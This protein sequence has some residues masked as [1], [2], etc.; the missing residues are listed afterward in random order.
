MARESPYRWGWLRTATTR[1][2]TSLDSTDL[3]E[4]ASFVGEDVLDLTQLLV[5]RGRSSPGCGVLGRVVHVTIP[6]D[7]ETVYEPDHLH[8]ATDISA[9][10]LTV[11]VKKRWKNIFK[12]VRNVKN[13]ENK[14]GLKT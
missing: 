13:V 6:V 14:K 3:C 11:D 8:T 10:S 2:F 9:T 4:C 12:N 7:P 1:S 5:Q